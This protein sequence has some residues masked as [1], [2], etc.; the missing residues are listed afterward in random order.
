MRIVETRIWA[1]LAL[2]LSALFLAGATGYAEEAPAEAAPAEAAPEEAP[3]AEEAP[4]PIAMEGDEARRAILDPMQGQPAPT[5]TLTDWINTEALTLESVKDK[6]VLLDFWGVWCG[7]CRAAVPHLKELHAK[8][9]D[10]GLV[11]LGVHTSTGRENAPA[12]V[13]EQEI[14]YPIGFDTTD[15]TVAA[16]QVDSFPDLYLIDHTGVLRYADLANADFANVENAI[17]QLLDERANALAPAEPAPAEPA[18]AE[19]A[20]AEPAPAEPA[21]AEPA[22]AEPAPAEPAPAEPAPAEAAPAEAAPAEEAPAEG[23]Q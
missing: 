5:W 1:G 8:Y 6:V 3:P 9:A 21:P 7:P 22:P 18:P 10:K 11:I 17:T 13:T 15:A 16:Y 12:Y 20:P 23:G 2:L 14:S 4:P 19:P